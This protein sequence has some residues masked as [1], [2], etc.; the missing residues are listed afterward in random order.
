MTPRPLA[1][2]RRVLTGCLCFLSIA[3]APCFAKA[4]QSA[5]SDVDS[6]AR[7]RNPCHLELSGTEELC[8]WIELGTHDSL[9]TPTRQI[10]V[11]P[12]SSI[13]TSVTVTAL[14]TA[15]CASAG[16]HVEQ[17]VEPFAMV[18]PYL[19][20]SLEAVDK[21]QDWW[22]EAVA[23]AKAQRTAEAQE[24][25]AKSDEI[26]VRVD[27]LAAL[28][29]VDVESY[30]P[31]VM[32]IVTEGDKRGEDF[33]IANDMLVGSSPMIV[34]LEEAYLPY[35]LAANDI[36]F[37][38]VV[39]VTTRPFC[40]RSRI[41]QPQ[42]TC[43]WKEA[44]QIVGEAVQ[45]VKASEAYAYCGS[46]DCH[47]D[48]LIWKLDN[49]IAD[50]SQFR[51]AV[52]PHAI[53]QRFAAIASS[54]NTLVKDATGLLASRWPEVTAEEASPSPA[55]AALL[56]R[57]GVIDTVEAIATAQPNAVPDRGAADQGAADARTVDAQPRVADAE[58]G[59]QLR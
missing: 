20:N 9:P 13:D 37:W 42:A 5:P 12:V 45:A 29:P 1:S 24:K 6:A 30:G 15:A 39:P 7:Y 52:Q 14:A 31:S 55:G 32:T 25:M 58:S 10:P 28:E 48:D 38:S 50:D 53:G 51:K 57:A 35:D 2:A 3:V 18:G 36:K 4:D 44:R 19:D 26:D 56:A 22:N 8:G 49:L 34:T 33:E 59:T 54:G 23:Q 16:V 40:V 47:L 21:L 41:E 43:M 11:L 17:I 27:A 46:A